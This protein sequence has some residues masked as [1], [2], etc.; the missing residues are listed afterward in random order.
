MVFVLASCGERTLYDRIQT[1]TEKIGYEYGRKRPHFGAFAIASSASKV[2]VGNC[3][4]SKSECQY[5]GGEG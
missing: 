1:E 4:C 5:C 3:R 2:S